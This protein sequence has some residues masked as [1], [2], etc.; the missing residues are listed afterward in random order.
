MTVEAFLE[1]STPHIPKPASAICHL[2]SKE[3]QKQNLNLN[4]NF[5]LI[6]NLV[7]Q[8]SA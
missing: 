7:K 8:E 4:F 6:F 2:W 1:R 5:H 3:V